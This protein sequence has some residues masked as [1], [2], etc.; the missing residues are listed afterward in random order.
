MLAK[1]LFECYAFKTSWDIIVYVAYPC[2]IGEVSML[3]IARYVCLV[4]IFL[5]GMTA[6]EAPNQAQTTPTSV[7]GF[8]AA[9]VYP[10]P[11]GTVSAQNPPGATALPGTPGSPQATTAPGQPPAPGVPGQS[12][13]LVGAEWN[14]IYQGDLNGDGAADVVA[15][16]PATVTLDAAF[17]Q[18]AYASYRGPIESLVIVQANPAGQPYVQTEMS[19]VLVRS[20]GNTITGFAGAAAHMVLVSPGSRPQISIQQV[21]ANGQP[22]G[23]PLGL[24]WDATTGRYTIF[25]GLSK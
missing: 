19:R 5:I 8:K 15:Y 21:G 12:S 20:A 25:T 4:G 1:A 18:P 7:V 22:L 2:V 23:K 13:A 17:T 24:N 16:K 3:Q 11:V 9:T 14:V 6:C 10:A